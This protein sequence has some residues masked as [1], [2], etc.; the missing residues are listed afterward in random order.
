MRNNKQDFLSIRRE[1]GWLQIENEGT[2]AE[3]TLV[4]WHKAGNYPNS[5]TYKQPMDR[6]AWTVSQDAVSGAW[7]THADEIEGLGSDVPRWII[8]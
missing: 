8:S 2:V 7:L 1:R 4:S 3:H 6:E 5:P